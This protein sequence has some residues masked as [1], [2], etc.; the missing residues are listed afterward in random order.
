MRVLAA[1]PQSDRKTALNH[2]RLHHPGTHNSLEEKHAL[3][4]RITRNA[5]DR[6]NRIRLLLSLG[7]AHPGWLGGPVTERYCR[8]APYNH[9]SDV[10][11]PRGD[12]W[13]GH[14]LPG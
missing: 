14:R 11:P 5:G 2:F 9:P 13:P 3:V 6:R 4:A 10:D 1:L 7:R 8:W 12:P